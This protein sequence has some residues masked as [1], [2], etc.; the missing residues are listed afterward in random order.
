M[1]ASVWHGP[2]RHG[3]PSGQPVT[4]LAWSCRT[5]RAGTARPRA[6]TGR[7]L[8]RYYLVT[9]RSW[10]DTIWTELK[11]VR[12]MPAPS[13]PFGHLYSLDILPE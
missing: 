3:G 12:V 6:L 2:F 8:A 9:G 13:D 5:S 7:F 10:P 4:I 11:R 1:R